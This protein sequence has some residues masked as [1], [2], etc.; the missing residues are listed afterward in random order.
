MTKN[1]EYIRT[2]WEKER[3]EKLSH[4]YKMILEYTKTGNEKA[5]VYWKEKALLLENTKY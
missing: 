1:P 5:I 4:C 2:K 3:N